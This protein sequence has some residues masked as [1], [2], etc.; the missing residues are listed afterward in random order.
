MSAHTLI[1]IMEAAL[2]L[3]SKINKSGELPQSSAGAHAIDICQ[4][5]LLLMTLVYRY[6]KSGLK[7][8]GWLYGCTYLV[9]SNGSSF[10]K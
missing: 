2:R 1:K 4:T 8:K 7:T 10:W 9:C 3:F 6:R 5:K